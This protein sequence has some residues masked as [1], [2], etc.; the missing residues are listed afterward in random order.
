MSKKQS[1]R[2]KPMAQSISKGFTKMRRNRIGE[3]KIMGLLSILP[4][5]PMTKR[6]IERANKKRYPEESPFEDYKPE[7][8]PCKG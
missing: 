7:D 8:E 5:P 2:S 1:S 4:P 6:E 3:A